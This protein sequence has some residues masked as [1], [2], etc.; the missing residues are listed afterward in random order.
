MLLRMLP[1]RRKRA[2][3]RLFFVGE[4]FCDA[5]LSGFELFVVF[6]HRFDEAWETLGQERL[7]QSERAAIADGAAQ[8]FAQ[9]IAAVD[10]A[11]LDA[12]GDGESKA[13]EVVGDDAKGGIAP[14]SL[15]VVGYAGDFFHFGDQ[16]A[17]NVGFEDVVDIRFAG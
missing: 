17:K 9:D 7:F 6:A 14:L 13:A 16:A 12:V 5:V 11:W 3:E 4:D 10:V 2:D 1:P 8:H 15:P